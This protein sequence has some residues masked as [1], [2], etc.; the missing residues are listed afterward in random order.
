MVVMIA[1]LS[2]ETVKLGSSSISGKNLNWA[3]GAEY[4]EGFETFR[5]DD[6][7]KDYLNDRLQEGFLRQIR[8]AMKPD[9]AYSL[10][11]S[12][13]NVVGQSKRKIHEDKEKRRR[14]PMKSQW[15]LPLILLISPMTE[16]GSSSMDLP[17]V[18]PSFSSPA[19]Y[20]S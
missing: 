18:C 15:L 4:G 12:W 9:E 8:Y 7:L 16:M 20:L 2:T 19:V 1:W 13:D 11:F 5:L 6:P 14:N 17:C 3:I 10:I